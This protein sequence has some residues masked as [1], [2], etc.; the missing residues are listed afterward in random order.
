MCARRYIPPHDKL[1]ITPKQFEGIK[2]NEVESIKRIN[3]SGSRGDPLRNPLFIPL[4]KITKD[5]DKQVT[6]STNGNFYTEIWWKT[7][8]QYLPKDHFVVFALDGIDED[9]LKFYRKGSFFLRVIEN[10]Q[11]FI[12]SGGRAIWQFILF[13]HNEH[14]LD[15]AKKMAKDLGFRDI[16]VIASTKYDKKFQRPSSGILSNMEYSD[17][18]RQKDGI[19]CRIQNGRVNISCK[20]EYLPCCFVFM[21]KQIKGVLGDEPIKYIQDY[22]LPEVLADGYY[23]RILKR[24]EKMDIPIC[25]ACNVHC[26]TPINQRD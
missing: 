12:S 18:R 15:D 1:F 17:D 25:R 21:E 11:A 14:L 2:I 23:D 20:G 19:I 8:P 4:I 10:A 13:K 7:L 22:S 6:I 9:S 3:I 5:W 16:L 24:V 26:N